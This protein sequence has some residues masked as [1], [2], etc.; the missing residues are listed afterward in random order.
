MPTATPDLTRRIVFKT[1]VGIATIPA[2][3]D[4]RNGDWISTDIYDAE[5]Y[6]NV[7]DGK[8]YT[9]NSGVIQEVGATTPEKN[10]ATDNL[11]ITDNTRTLK[12][13]GNLFTDT[14]QIQNNGSSTYLEVTG[15]GKVGI[16]GV[17]DN[18]RICRVYGDFQADSRVYVGTGGNAFVD[19]SIVNIARYGGTSLGRHQFT[20]NTGTSYFE[21]YPAGSTITAN[22]GMNYVFGT[23][24]GSKLGT[25]T[26][27]KI[28]FW[29]VTPVVQPAHIADP[30]GGATIDAEA[31][32]AINSINA[33]LAATGLTASS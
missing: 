27:Q 4:H 19:G 14:V 6:L 9:S 32:T 22:D 8:L 23:T 2:S 17:A 30:S 21:I 13:A 12:L 20:N 29:N 33:M 3:S 15:N 10:I 31:R 16:G 24:N 5:L 1:G 26:S 25:A 11:T 28:G 18:A 7:T